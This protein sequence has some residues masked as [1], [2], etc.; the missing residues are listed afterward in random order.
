LIALI[1][2]LLTVGTTAQNRRRPAPSLTTEDVVYGRRSVALPEP[3]P[4]T[5]PR[6]EKSPGS[7]REPLASRTIDWR[8]QLGDALNEASRDGRMVVVDVY[9]DWCVWCH[10]MDDNI[11]SSPQVAALSRDVVFLKLDAEDGGEGQRF[12]RQAGV[13]GFPTTF[14]LSG[15]GAV[16]EKAVGYVRS[17]S[18]FVAIV[19]RARARK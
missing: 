12:A 3:V 15:S 13:T 6:S 11:Y 7:K 4:E 5:V 1:A 18:A 19:E 16:L 2:F 10:R 8:R 9:T 17:P 14:V